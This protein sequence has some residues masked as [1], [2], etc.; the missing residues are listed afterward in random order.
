MFYYNTLNLIQVGGGTQVKQGDLGSKFS[1]KLANEKDQELDDF[2]KEVARINL[3][4][5]DKIVFTTTATVDNS[6]VTFNIDQALPVGLYFLEIKIRD[7]IFPSDKQTNIF[8]DSGAAVYKELVPNYDVNM[9]LDGIL[10]D[11]TQKG[12]EI[13]AARGSYPNLK[14]RLDN[15]DKKQQQTSL[16][17]AEKANKDEVTNV[18]T[19]KGTLAYASL[20]MTGNSVG[21][22]YYCPDGDGTHGAGNYVW[23]GTSWYFGGTGDEGYNLLKKDIGELIFDIDLSD[24]YNLLDKNN[25]Y[26]GWLYSLN[27]NGEYF[28]LVGSN[29]AQTN[30]IEVAEGE[31]L[32]IYGCTPSRDPYYITLLN[33]NDI[34]DVNKVIKINPENEFNGL[35]YYKYTVPSDVTLLSIAFLNKFKNYIVITAKECTFPLKMFVPSNKIEINR[36]LNTK[37]IY[38][39]LKGITLPL[40][41]HLE[42]L[43]SF[44]NS[45]YYG[46]DSNAKIYYQEVKCHSGDTILTN[47]L[48]ENQYIL[49]EA[50]DANKNIIRK[51]KYKGYH[52]DIV[53]KG[54]KYCRCY[55]YEADKDTFEIIVIRNDHSYADT[56]VNCLGDS[57]TYGYINSSLRA[58]PTWCETVSKNLGCTVN[59][60]GVSG[61]SVCNGSSESFV[62]RLNNMS[63]ENIDMLFIF[64]GTNDYG[65]KRAVTLGTINDTPEQGTNFYA[66]Y[67]YLIEQAFNKYP[68]AQIAVVTPMRRSNYVAN[69]YGISMED[70]VNAE[71]K[72]AEYYGLPCFDF[73]HHGGINPAI[74]VHKNMFAPDGLHPNQLGIDTFLS[75]R[76]TE[77]VREC[78]SYRP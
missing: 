31:V 58:S 48:N 34:N 59:N 65:D 10:S 57:I 60:Y 40:G 77:F 66:S 54:T 6:T 8:V 16:Q 67:K 68:S 75:P 13:T 7:Y 11:L 38:S 76:F 36:R 73:Y 19:P 33:S 71:I 42:N 29:Y 30:I 55:F 46:T 47:S 3:V 26:Y 5:D 64:G 37:S 28:K 45:V 51:F 1:Y 49:I 32:T 22:Y 17:L 63:E 15:V 39:I 23:N 24:E 52:I 12:A 21:W 70:I 9:T 18:M 69:S 78:I 4:L 43:F 20:P 74:A 44:D 35:S 50:L 14:G 27:D 72:I 25:S 41:K 61:T 2:D 62:T 56:V 53:P